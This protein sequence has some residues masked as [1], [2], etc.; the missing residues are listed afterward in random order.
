VTLYESFVDSDA[1]FL[2]LNSDSGDSISA[3]CADRAVGPARTVV[4]QAYGIVVILVVIICK[5]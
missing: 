3:V 5:G 1:F 4:F 2:A